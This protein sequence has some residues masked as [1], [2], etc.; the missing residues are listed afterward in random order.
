MSGAGAPDLT[1]RAEGMRVAVVAASWHGEL[2]EAMAQE[3]IAAIAESG[4]SASLFSVA[5][6]FELPL[7]AQTALRSG[8]DA[9]VGLA[10]IERGETPHF[11]FVAN[12][13]TD[14][15]T[16]VQLDE[17]KPVGFGVLTVDTEDQARNRSGLPGSR[18]SKGR[19]AAEAAL[20]LAVSNRLIA[21]S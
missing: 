13:V 14:G 9:V 2:T 16:R 6:S 5:G 17:G 10:V 21:D 4:A 20:H 15:L 19:E 18:E 3:A 8:F 1:V 11:D 12:A 7:A